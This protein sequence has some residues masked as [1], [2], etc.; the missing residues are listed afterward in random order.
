MKKIVMLSFPFFLIFFGFDAVQQYVTNFFQEEGIVQAGFISLALIYFCFAISTF[1]AARAVSKYGA[2]KCMIFSA[3]FYG[4][5]IFSLLG[6]FLVLIYLASA[7]IGF[8][9]AFLWTAA[10]SYVIRASTEKNYGANSGF[11]TAAKN[12]GSALGTILIGLFLIRLSF[13]SSFLIFAFFPLLGSL[14]L[15]SLPD[16]RVEKNTNN[17][18]FFRNLFINKMSLQLSIVQFYWSFVLGLVIGIIPLQIGSILGK[19]YVGILSS[20]YFVILLSS[21]SFGKISDRKKR[22]IMIILSYITCL[23]GLVFLY[24]AKSAPILIFG[25]IFIGITEAVIIPVMNAVIGD[26]SKEYAESLTALFLLFQTIGVISALLLSQVLTTNISLIYL[27][28]I[29][30]VIVS[31]FISPFLRKNIEQ[32]KKEV[33]KDIT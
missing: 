27:I 6:K 33:V 22:R 10:N 12:L 17:P 32:L 20:L 16:V 26:I 24:F 15:T 29:A 5:F 2:K 19:Q 28:S 25:F 31:F 14:F 4:L 21:Y 23:F 7:L 1:F 3:I 9:A 13:N 30:V 18:G 11:F 8:S